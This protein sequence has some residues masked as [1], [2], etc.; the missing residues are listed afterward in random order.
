MP[1]LLDEYIDRVKDLPPSPSVMIELM[2]MLEM[3]DRD[4]DQ[5]IGLISHDL[6]LTAEILRRCNSA[7]FGGD[8]QATD[9]FEAT[10]R[11]GFHEVYRIV[12]ALF[13][14]RAMQ[15]AGNSNGAALE[16]VWEHSALTA[17]AAGLLARELQEGEGVSFTA[18]LLHD[19]GKVVLSCVEGRKYSESL[20]DVAPKDSM[21]REL[22]VF[23]FDHSQI[24]TRLLARWEFPQ[25]IIAAVQ[26]HHSPSQADSFQ[27][28]TALLHLA[29]AMAYRL[30]NR[31]T[32]S[33]PGE[34][35]SS[36]AA[37]YS[38]KLLR[39]TPEALGSMTGSVEEEAKR[40]KQLFKSGRA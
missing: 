33:T 8:E 16:K 34:F 40:V 35:E 31:T 25:K 38:M 13:G 36:P 28:L 17:V 15:C 24:G 2:A 26:H 18:G 37:S 10:F 4:I 21:Q 14:M 11:L 29:D 39:I 32:E 19:L 9:I 6:S 3:P 20:Q 7:Y 22:E 27:R 12:S 1:D 5:L 23:G 30:A